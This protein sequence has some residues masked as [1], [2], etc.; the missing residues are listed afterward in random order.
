MSDT[1]LSSIARDVVGQYQQAGQ[2]LVRACRGGSE[3]L[4][5]GLQAQGA[6]LLGAQGPDKL[7]GL[8][9]RSLDAATEVAGRAMNR[10]AQGAVVGIERVGG[11]SDRL[12][13]KLDAAGLAMVTTLQHKAAATSLQIA[14]KVTQLSQRLSVSLAGEEPAIRVAKPARKT[15]RK[16]IRK[17]AAKK[18]VVRGTRRAA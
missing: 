4:V 8:T 7:A 16:P 5:R 3:R 6:K 18:Q 13:A 15:A 11:T 9:I 2:H 1:T 14:G 12:E 10:L 17:T